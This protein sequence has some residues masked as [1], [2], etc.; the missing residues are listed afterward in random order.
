MS[1][2]PPKIGVEI[3]ANW[4][5]FYDLPYAVRLALEKT[6]R[7]MG[8]RAASV[9]DYFKITHGKAQNLTTIHPTTAPAIAEFYKNLPTAYHFPLGWDKWSDSGVE[10]RFDGPADT[11]DAAKS[12]LKSG[13]DWLHAFG[14]GSFCNAGTHVHLGHVAWLDERFG[15]SGPIR[16]KAEA[17]LW[18]YFASRERAIFDIAPAHRL[19]NDY[20]TPHFVN[21]PDA[22][23]RNWFAV[24]HSPIFTLDS[25]TPAWALH[26]HLLTNFTPSESSPHWH[27]GFSG[28][29]I[30]NRRKRF[31]TIEFRNFAGT[32]EFTAVFGYVKF[33]YTMFMN[34]A[35]V[36]TE[37]ACRA[38][39][40]DALSAPVIV[41]PYHYTVADFKKEV[42]DP[43]L[44]KW[45]DLTVANRGEP[46]SQEIEISNEPYYAT[47]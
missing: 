32:R 25:R 35:A 8:F 28:G 2:K 9:Y 45:I 26:E 31:P 4:P 11:L 34:A 6:A 21:R 14:H 17:L 13:T 41:N 38:K 12:L 20:C 15:L 16:G 29:A 1:E 33:L 3:E 30:C 10:M 43:W 7:V 37:G 36:V 47:A 18:G 44:L 42:D 5:N 19:Q 22:A 24:G 46:I 39:T 40:E 23:A 27:G